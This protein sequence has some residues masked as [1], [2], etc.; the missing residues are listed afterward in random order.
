MSIFVIVNIASIARLAWRNL[1]WWSVPSA[2]WGDLPGVPPWQQVLCRGRLSC[3]VSSGCLKQER[4][5]AVVPDD[6]KLI[7]ARV[8]RAYWGRNR[9]LCLS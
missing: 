6:A 1:R 4:R 5:S 2:A 7:A 9:R 3:E 8:Q